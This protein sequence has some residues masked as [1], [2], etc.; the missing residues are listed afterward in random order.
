MTN[1]DGISVFDQGRLAFLTGKSIHDCP[2]HSRGPEYADWDRGWRAEKSNFSGL[3]I[4]QFF[5]YQHL[6]RHLQNVSR[7]FYILAT[8]LASELPADA[9]RGMALRKLLEAKDCA[10]RSALAKTSEANG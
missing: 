8:N 10:V 9:E 2:Y 1:K 7:Q 6:P 4:M 3:E 5:G